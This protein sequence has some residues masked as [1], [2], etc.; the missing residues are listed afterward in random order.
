MDCGSGIDHAAPIGLAL[1]QGGAAPNGSQ[2]ACEDSV[3][4]QRNR[5]TLRC[6]SENLPQTRAMRDCLVHTEAYYHTKMQ[7][8]AAR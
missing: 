4:L 7:A 8:C 1:A 6:T 3:R 2:R 5:D